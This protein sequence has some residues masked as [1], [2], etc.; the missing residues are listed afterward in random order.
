MV[1]R[2]ADEASYI[3]AMGARYHHNSKGVARD[4]ASKSSYYK[5]YWRTHQ[6]SDHL[7][8]WAALKIDFGREYLEAVSG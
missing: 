6:M 7:P 8:L 2:E 4:A 1:Y 5:T 3:E